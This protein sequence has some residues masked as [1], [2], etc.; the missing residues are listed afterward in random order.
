MQFIT[1]WGRTLPG[2]FHDTVCSFYAASTISNTPDWE[3]IPG[4][5]RC[6][7]CSACIV[8]TSPTQEPAITRFGIF[9]PRELQQYEMEITEGILDFRI[10]HGW[11]YTYHDRIAKYL[12]WIKQELTRNP[13]SRRAAIVI[14]SDDDLH[15]DSP[16][17]LQHIQFQV[18][19]GV[20]NNVLDMHVLF[21]SNDLL[22][23]TFMN[24]WGL[25]RLQL[26]LANELGISVG[27]YYHTV[28]NLHVYERDWARLDNY[29]KAIH[30]RQA[31]DLTYSYKSD[32]QALMQSEI[33]SIMEMVEQLKANVEADAD[34]GK[35]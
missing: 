27:S 14:R 26:K 9:G 34:G 4:Q 21:R 29:V 20:E 6:Q 25:T 18:R 28:N 32:W 30:G 7:E 35:R 24:M 22:N 19:P 13:F 17:C 12:P 8:V 11:D 33:P 10:G 23:A 31:D 3:A 2:A 5:G 16:A 15:S 1:G